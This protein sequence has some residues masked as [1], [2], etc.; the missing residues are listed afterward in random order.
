MKLAGVKF[1]HGKPRMS[2]IPTAP[3]LEIAKAFTF[4]AEKYGDHNW[5]NGFTWTRIS[6]AVLRHVLAWKEG[7]D[8][9]PESGLSHLAHAACGI[10]FLLEFELKNIG[11]D[12]RYKK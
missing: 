11:K 2:L 4:G 7:E 8:K 1:D 3:L 12:D 10:L 6:D 5:R 9:D